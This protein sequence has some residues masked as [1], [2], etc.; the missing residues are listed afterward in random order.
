MIDEVGSNLRASLP[1]NLSTDEQANKQAKVDFVLELATR[2][3]G[4]RKATERMGIS[5]PEMIKGF[6][7]E[8]EKD[9]IEEFQKKH[10]NLSFNEKLEAFFLKK[11]SENVEQESK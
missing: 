1:Y 4:M 3:I 9:E 2:F 5:Y 11:L 8:G 6:W 7:D 10:T